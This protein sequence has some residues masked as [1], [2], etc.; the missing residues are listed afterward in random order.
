MIIQ[1]KV[2]NTDLS[3][4]TKIDTLEAELQ[5]WLDIPIGKLKEG[6]LLIKDLH[7]ARIH[8]H[9]IVQFINDVQM[10]VSGADIALNAL[11]NSVMGFNN[12]ITYRD[13]IS[14]YIYPNTLTVLKIDGKTLKMALHKDVQY[15][16]FK[17]NEIIVRKK[18][19]YPKPQHYNYDMYD[20][21]SYEIV[22]GKEE[23]L[24]EN[25]RF[26]GTLIEDKDEFTIVMNNYRSAGGGVFTM[27]T[28]L[29]VVADI[30][31]DM[32]EII[33]EY[34]MKKKVINVVNTNNIIVKK[35]A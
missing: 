2:I 17:D 5:E 9:D 24:V 32:V 18:Y 29:P 10:D 21:I 14:T 26:K 31:K 3:L 12:E 30:Q 28:G 6:N 35:K 20:G 13:I 4:L 22:V 27:F 1:P 8:K 25:L 7:E 19:A 16:D 15:F 33:A 34:I 23:S 11:A